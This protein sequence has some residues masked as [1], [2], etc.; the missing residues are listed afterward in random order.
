MVFFLSNIHIWERVARHWN[1]MNMCAPG[2]FHNNSIHRS[3]VCVFTF[4]F[5]FWL[6]MKKELMNWKQKMI[7]LL[8]KKKTES[9]R[10]REGWG[11]S[12][13]R[14]MK[15]KQCLNNK[16]KRMKDKEGKKKSLLWYIQRNVLFSS[17]VCITVIWFLIYDRSRIGKSKSEQERRE[18]LKY[19]VTLYCILYE[20]EDP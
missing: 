13:H 3:F 7:Y 4:H 17:T 8:Q 1:N 9:K 20:I 12:A 11:K 15:K 19:I 2:C 6:E 5:F 14:Q 18:I 16:Y 10:K